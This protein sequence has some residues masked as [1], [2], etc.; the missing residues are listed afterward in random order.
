MGLEWTTLKYIEDA[1]IW[2]RIT[3]FVVALLVLAVLRY[4]DWL[5]FKG[6]WYFTGMLLSLIVFYAAVVGYASWKYEKETGRPR[7]DIERLAGAL[8]EF[9]KMIMKS[10][11]LLQKTSKLLDIPIDTLPDE[12]QKKFATDVWWEF[13][14]YHTEMSG[15]L[16]IHQYDRDE[17]G[18]I[19]FGEGSPFMRPESVNQYAQALNEMQPNNREIYPRIMKSRDDL[20]TFRRD[21]ENGSSAL[22]MP[23]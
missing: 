20:V 14:Q 21:F 22:K 15:F 2:L 3:T 4:K 12:E 5:D 18:A 9:S 13:Q 10:P 16:N 19:A 8:P 1:P 11:Y 23:S 6:R 7:A 17:F